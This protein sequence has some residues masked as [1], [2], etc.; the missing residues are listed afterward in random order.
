MTEI[1]FLQINIDFKSKL[2]AQVSIIIITLKNII[3]AI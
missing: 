3:M 2:Q 1:E